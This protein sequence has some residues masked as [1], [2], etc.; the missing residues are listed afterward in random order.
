M[1]NCY[2]CFTFATIRQFCDYVRRERGLPPT[3]RNMV[4]WHNTNRAMVVHLGVAIDVI[5]IPIPERH[6][7]WIHRLMRYFSVPYTDTPQYLRTISEGRRISGYTG[8]P[9][10]SQTIFKWF[11]N[12]DK[13]HEGCGIGDALSPLPT[14]V[15]HVPREGPLRLVEGD[16]K[17]GHYVCLSHRWSAEDMPRSLR[18]NIESLMHEIPMEWLTQTFRDS[19]AFV[20]SFS[21]WFASQDP[22]NRSVEY[23]WIDSICIIQDSAED[24]ASESKE[25]CIPSIGVQF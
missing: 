19:I 23:L 18:S 15:I 20:R 12:C 11:E 7:S 9:S 16:G 6:F 3:E 22:N 5:K 1:A 13:N 14:R 21:S 17:E 24:W 10:A 4:F 25:K 8:S 2:G